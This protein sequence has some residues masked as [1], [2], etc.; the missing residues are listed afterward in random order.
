M[1]GTAFMQRPTKATDWYERGNLACI[2]GQIDRVRGFQLSTV[3][4]GSLAFVSLSLLVPQQKGTT[5]QTR[6]NRTEGVAIITYGND[7]GTKRMLGKAIIH[8]MVPA[9]AL[10]I[11]NALQHIEMVDAIPITSEHDVFGRRFYMSAHGSD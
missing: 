11:V 8:T 1:V 2:C 5:M 4:G 9:Q 3:Q 10:A 6:I 7:H